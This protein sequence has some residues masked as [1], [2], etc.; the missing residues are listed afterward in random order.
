M[1]DILRKIEA[2][3][4]DEIAAAKALIPLAEIRA[5]AKDADAPRGFLAALEAKH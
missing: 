3:K 1:S 4:R 2:Y 5:Q